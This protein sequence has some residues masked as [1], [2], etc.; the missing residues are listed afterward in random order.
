MTE[1]DKVIQ[2]VEKK[3]ALN[4][5]TKSDLLDASIEAI[6]DEKK[7][8]KL[9]KES[10]VILLLVPVITAELWDVLVEMKGEEDEIEEN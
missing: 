7:L 1:I 6:K 10:P 8:G 4:G 3:H 9:I 5:I 2:K